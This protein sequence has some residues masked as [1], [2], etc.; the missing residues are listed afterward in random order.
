[1]HWQK[2]FVPDTV[3]TML[4]FRYGEC[5]DQEAQ[6]LK[7]PL[8]RPQDPHHSSMGPLQRSSAFRTKTTAFQ[9]PP[10]S[11][12]QSL[13]RSVNQ[14]SIKG[15]G[16]DMDAGL[17]AYITGLNPSSQKGF[18]RLDRRTGMDSLQIQDQYL[19]QGSTSGNTVDFKTD[20]LT[21]VKVGQFVKH[22]LKTQ[23]SIPLDLQQP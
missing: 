8:R 3:L 21:F 14:P 7:P 18:C 9:S 20:L 13:S 4:C 6:L 22:N 17:T 19:S 11:I 12:T 10:S 23:V 16:Q 15:T 2:R 1:M 5:E